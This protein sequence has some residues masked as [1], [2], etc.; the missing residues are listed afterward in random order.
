MSPEANFAVAIAITLAMSLGLTWLLWRYLDPALADYC[1]NPVRGRV[2]SVLCSA[3]LVV[4]PLFALTLEL[5][6][7]D[8]R[9]SWLFNVFGHLRW[10]LMAL[11]LATLMVSGIVMALHIPRDLPMTRSEIDDMKRLLG[12]VQEVRARDILNRAGATPAVDPKELEELNRLV[13][14]IQAVRPRNVHGRGDAHSA[15]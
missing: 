7:S 5:R 9:P 6:P 1:G 15:N 14:K 10:P 13:D 8:P 3:L 12:K 11:V 4:L 2:W